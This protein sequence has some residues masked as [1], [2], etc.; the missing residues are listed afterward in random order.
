MSNYKELTVW[1]LAIEL[2]ARLHALARSF[3]RSGAPGLKSQLLRAVGSIHSNIAEG[4]D[5]TDAEYARFITV[6]IGSANETESHLIHA[7]RIGLLAKGT[8]ATLQLEIQEI[9]RMLFGL[10][11]YLLSRS[12]NSSPPPT[13]GPAAPAESP[14]T[15]DA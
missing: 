3:P 15:A 14:R 8:G 10:R 9:R 7:T 2:S 1:Q 4:S 5:A 11:K 6:A 13:G 12:Q